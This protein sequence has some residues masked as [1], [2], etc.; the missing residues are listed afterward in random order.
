MTNF[1]LF[2]LGVALMLVIMRLQ[3]IEDQAIELE[4]RVARL[5]D[6]VEPLRE[7]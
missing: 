2:I 4:D 5:E 1:L 7:R 6:Q 3:K